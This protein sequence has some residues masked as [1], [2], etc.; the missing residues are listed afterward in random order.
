M[1]L[2]AG[3]SK[4]DEM[5]L[6]LEQTSKQGSLMRILDLTG[7]VYGQLTVIVLAD[8]KTK[9]RGAMWLCGCSCGKT[10]V[11]GGNNL[12][13]GNTK[14]CGCTRYINSSASRRSHGMSQSTEYR[15]WGLMKARCENKK[16][17]RYAVYGG[18]GIVVCER[19]RKFEN[20]YA[21]MGPRPQKHSLDRIDTNLG[22]SPENCRWADH[23]TQQRN[24]R[25]NRVISALG[26][27]QCV[28]VWEEETGIPASVLSRR[29]ESGWSA[30]RAVSEASR[31]KPRE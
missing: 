26:K 12:Q 5:A 3:K 1:A 15:I 9:R 25:N 18:R 19:W 13:S 7:R 17:S 11:V 14:S 2:C 6:R 8:K 21:D 24:R 20:F 29:I 27:T 10:K 4:G 30:E 28:A 16:N 31:G 23:K 22:Y